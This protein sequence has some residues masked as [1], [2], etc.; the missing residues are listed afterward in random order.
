MSRFSQSELIQFLSPTGF[1]I[2]IQV[3]C[4]SYLVLAT[5]HF[6]INQLLIVTSKMCGQDLWN[7][8]ISSKDVGQ[9]FHWSHDVLD[10]LFGDRF[11][12]HIF[13]AENWFSITFKNNTHSKKNSEN[14]YML[15][16][17]KRHTSSRCELFSKLGSTKNIRTMSL[18]LFGYLYC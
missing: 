15:K 10:V 9:F 11:F 16:V 13:L 14:K 12:L 6:R 4:Y 2:I 17:N 7:S 3:H 18:T 5:S 1:Q 8:E